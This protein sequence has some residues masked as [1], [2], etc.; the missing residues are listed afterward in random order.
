VNLG[1]FNYHMRFWDWIHPS[2]RDLVIDQLS[3]SPDM[4]AHYLKHG[5][6]AAI[7]LA[8]SESGGASGERKFP[9]LVH[10]GSWDVLAKACIERIYEDP[11]EN[12]LNIFTVLESA[13]STSVSPKVSELVFQVCSAVKEYWEREQSILSA[14]IIKRFLALCEKTG[15]YIEAPSL[16]RS[17]MSACNRMKKEAKEAGDLP[18]TLT[19]HSLDHWI[20]FVGVISTTEPRLIAKDSLEARFSQDISLYIGAFESL[21]EEE[22][23]DEDPDKYQDESE[24]FTD[25]A[26]SAE[27]LAPLF[28]SKEKEIESL[29]MRLQ[30]RAEALEEEGSELKHELGLV[31]PDY[32]R[33]GPSHGGSSFDLNR[34]F[35]DL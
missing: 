8:L 30:E 21:L 29:V 10:E 31:E 18:Q 34:L 15:R 14:G 11:K 3:A 17:W 26:G 24:N 23:S 35:E 13:T 20:S 1:R 7:S 32:D 9:L 5:G 12:T 27:S 28:T 2:Q 16:E 22:F 4:S 33:E 25:I 19:V 6:I